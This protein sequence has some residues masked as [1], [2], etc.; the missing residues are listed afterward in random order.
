MGTA[1]ALACGASGGATIGAP[2]CTAITCDGSNPDVSGVASMASVDCSGQTAYGAACVVTAT[3]GYQTGTVTCGEGLDSSGT[4]T[5]VA[6]A[7][8]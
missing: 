7:G 6:G 1:S 2:T 3:T 8:T 4:Y 5:V